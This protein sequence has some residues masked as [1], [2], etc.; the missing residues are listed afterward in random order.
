VIVAVPAF[1][2]LTSP[3]ASTLATLG[4]LLDHVIAV[5]A[6]RAGVNTTDV[7]DVVPAVSNMAE[8]T[9]V[10]LWTAG[11]TVIVTEEDWEPQVAVIVTVP[12]VS[13]VTIAFC[14]VC[15]RGR[16]GALMRFEFVAVITVAIAE[17]E[18]DHV[19]VLFVAVEGLTIALTV[20]VWF[21]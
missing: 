8:G 17:L 21:K 9:R 3:V 2:A 1:R 13:P 12:R 14:G 7:G 11:R 10:M 16:N 15:A 6:E 20:T 5:V 18:L 4:L 19:T